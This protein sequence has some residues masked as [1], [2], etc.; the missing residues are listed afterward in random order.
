MNK[1]RIPFQNSQTV[2][3]DG[4]PGAAEIFTL[5]DSSVALGKRCLHQYDDNSWFVYSIFPDTNAVGNIVTGQFSHDGGTT[6]TTFYTSAALANN[7][8]TVDEVYVGV[9]SD[10]RF[11]YT[12]GASAQTVFRVNMSLG[13]E[14]CGP[15]G[16]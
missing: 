11:R 5:F 3:G 8:T 12:N 16:L 9:Y 6:W 15:S 2:S 1:T 14:N 7:V 4:L 13:D 10:V